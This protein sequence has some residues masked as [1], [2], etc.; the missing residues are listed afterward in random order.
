ML[1]QLTPEEL[2]ELEAEFARL[3]PEEQ[4]LLEAAS[5]AA[6]A[7]IENMNRRLDETLAYLDRAQ[8]FFDATDLAR[9]VHGD[10][11][12][13]SRWLCTPNADLGGKAPLAVLKDEDGPS[14]VIKCLRLREAGKLPS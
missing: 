4:A 3:T 8:H 7:A 10:N 13:A 2:Q 9:E 11:F 12:A 14:R 1:N 5:I 6:E